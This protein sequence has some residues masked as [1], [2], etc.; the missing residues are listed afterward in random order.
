MVNDPISVPASV[1]SP[2]SAF[3]EKAIGL[4]FSLLREVVERHHP[5]LVP[6]LSGASGTDL[7]PQMLGRAIQAQGILFQL[8]SI[9]EQNGAMRK[10]R[11]VERLDGRECLPG[12]FANV[13]ASARKAGLSAERVRDAFAGLKVRPVLTAHP[14][15]AKRVTVL[16][17]HRRIYRLLIDLESPRWTPRERADMEGTLRNE[18]ELLWLTGELRLEK[19]NVSQEIAWGLHFFNE[20]LF[21]VAPE[22][23][24]RADEAMLQHFG[25]Q[26]LPGFLEFGSWIGGDRD[27]NPFVTNAITRGALVECRMASLRRHR[28]S[29]L[30]LVRGLSVTEASLTLSGDFRDALTLALEEDGDG[31]AIAAR[32]PG[33]PFRQFLVCMLNKLDHAIA[34]AQ[35]EDAAACRRGYE[36]ADRLMADLR[37]LE[38]GLRDANLGLLAD[39]EVVPVRR[40]VEVFR[41]STVRLDVRENSTRVTQTLEAL[42]RASRGEPDDV[43]PPEQTSDEWCAWLLA[44]LAQPRSAQCD[45]GGLPAVAQETLG[46]FRLIAEMRP[47]VGREAFGS[48][49]LSMTRNVPDVLGVY[50]LAKEAGLYADPGGVE[51][52]SLPIMPLFETIEDLRRAPAIMRELLAMPL[53]KR[54]VRALG[55]VQEVMIGYSDSNKDGGFLSSNW[56]LFKAQMKL[57]AV[58]VDAGVKIAFFHGRGGSVSRG[59]VPAGRAIAAQPAGS[60]QG[61]FRLTEQ[62]EVIS[63]KY[64]NKG[65][66]AFNLELLAASV[67]DHALRSGRA[68]GLHSVP[69]FD[70]A[71]EALS[72]A[73]HAAYVNLISHPGLVSYFQEASPLEEI[74]LLNIGSRPARRFGAKSLSE[75]RAIPWVFAW[76]QNRHIVT[77]WYGVGSSLANFIEVRGASGEALLARMFEESPP[78]RLIVDEVEKT[79]A[80]VDLDIAREYSQ[81]VGDASVRDEV[82]GMIARE[83]ETTR[84]QILR[85]S[86]TRVLAER[87][88]EYREKLDHRL[89]VVNQVSRQQI[90]LLSAF[91]NTEDAARKEEFRKALLLSINC[92]AAGFGATG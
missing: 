52:C 45:L 39:S 27:G 40:Q 88:P 51:R 83:Y 81:L 8:L 17:R 14:T 86:G 2:G 53:I 23:L 7:S 46:L 70:D 69:E 59:G 13:L 36:S 25:E 80:V 72:G 64:A 43:M 87:F 67:F 85:L 66:A 24:A 68:D 57:S 21:E 58:G 35:G 4:L 71:L 34:C 48:F 16:E 3:S 75:L 65:T 38:V 91:R 10:R 90:S 54:S 5:E 50:L 73:A 76:S 79:L 42:W 26:D 82:F 78:F 15:E 56:E 30:E 11:E 31:S 61:L 18:I 32:N 49:I 19:P 63:S 1:D 74:S 55:G 28:A 6:V 12:T 92:V 84:A 29:V 37:T 20:T 62:G 41:F 9:A 77:G 47:K 89:P 33:E 60:I 44:E 22:V